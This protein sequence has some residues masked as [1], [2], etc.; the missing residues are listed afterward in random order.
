MSAGAAG[1]LGWLASRSRVL[2]REKLRITAGLTV[3]WGALWYVV[4]RH[5]TS[6]V[7][8]LPFTA[9]EARL[10]FVE[11]FVYAYLSLCLFMPLGAWLAVSPGLLRRHAGGFLAVTLTAF[12]CFIVYP[13]EVPAPTAAPTT[14]LYGLLLHDTRL[15]ALPSLHAAY[16]G[17]AWLA[18][19]HLL[20]DIAGRRARRAVAALVT[21]WA[22]L[23]LASILLIKQHYLVDVV[24]GLV[25]AAGAHV[26][27]L[28]RRAEA[29]RLVVPSIDPHAEVRT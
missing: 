22:L 9:L 20:P 4:P 8:V 25:L 29:P 23:I 17:Y 13:V 27:W 18:W 15:N 2:L 19:R 24:A 3:L 10:P 6:A 1:V 26:L 21:G 7:H 5:A 16:T 28:G 11:S 12:A 14:R